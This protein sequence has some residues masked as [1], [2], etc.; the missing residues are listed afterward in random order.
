MT[1]IAVL[2]GGPAGLAAAWW[3]ARAGHDVVLFEQAPVTGGM[4]GSFQIDGIRADFGSHRLHPAI[5]VDILRDLQSLPGLTLAR[6]PRR[7]RIRIAGRWLAFPLSTPDLVRSLPPGMALSTGFDALTTWLRRPRADTFA[8]VVRTGLG[9]TMADR[10][11]GPYARKL[12]GLEA[13]ALSGEQ[14]RR[15]ISAATPLALARRVL[16]PDPNSGWFLYPPNGFGAIV[17]ALDAAAREAGADVRTDNRVEGV[18]LSDQGVGV[19]AG[20]TAHEADLV[21]STLPVGALTRLVDPVPPKVIRTAAQQLRT[22]A[23]VLVYL[24][25]DGRFS[26]FDAHY[27]PEPLTP[28]TR[29][30]EP[31][32]YRDGDDPP[33]RSLLCAE[34]PCELA[35][36]LWS[37]DDATLADIVQAGIEALGLHPPNVRHFESRRV[38]HAYPVMTLDAPAARDLLDAWVGGLPR[39]LSF[40][41]H[42]LYAHDNTH[43]ALAEARA[44]VDAIGAG[45]IDRHAWDQSRSAFAAHVVED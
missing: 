24:V 3:A 40:G 7:G 18:Q 26:T 9:P 17:E 22:R 32:N 2:G 20:G 12:W 19:V 34:I 10:F 25:I 16:R 30:S 42:G 33:D 11:Y 29:L 35:D 4:A 6:R 41:R 38:P 36:H 27:I 8:E 5:D 1:R 39:L 15:R 31:P 44:A 37:A 21:L 28:M 13:T 43:H 45:G 14:A 23:M